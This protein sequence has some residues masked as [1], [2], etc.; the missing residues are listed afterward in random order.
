MI[1]L[2]LLTL[3]SLACPHSASAQTFEAYVFGGAGRWVHNTGSSGP[4]VVGGGGGEWMPTRHL[5]IAGD[6]GLLTSPGGSV[7]LA[8]SVD[9]R[10]HFRAGSAAGTWAPY[11]F[12]GYT[13]FGLFDRSDQGLQYGTG[14]DYRLSARRALRLEVRDILR[15]S[16]SVRSHYWT[17]R[18]GL[19]FR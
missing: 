4:L 8:V 15:E 5:G 2:V 1:R 18:V 19:T 11:V 6:A 7:G 3:L 13:P 10:L 14:A 17:A 12:A 16:G 9:V